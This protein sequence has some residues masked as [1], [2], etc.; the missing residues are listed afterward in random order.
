MNPLQ[1]IQFLANIITEAKRGKRFT[2]RVIVAVK[3]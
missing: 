2:E 1:A 3:V